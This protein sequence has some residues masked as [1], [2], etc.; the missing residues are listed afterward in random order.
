MASLAELWGW[1]MQWMGSHRRCDCCLC[2]EAQGCAPCSDSA[3]KAASTV[4]C[5]PFSSSHDIHCFLPQVCLLNSLLR[6]T[7][8]LSCS[9]AI[10]A[11]LFSHY[12]TLSPPPLVFVPRTW[13]TEHPDTCAQMALQ[14][15]TMAN[16]F[17]LSPALLQA[18]CISAS[19]KHCGGVKRHVVPALLSAEM[20]F[21]K[22]P[23]WWCS[24]AEGLVPDLQLPRADLK[25][26][27]NLA[28]SMN[29]WLSRETQTLLWENMAL[30]CPYLAT[31]QKSVVELECLISL[32][33]TSSPLTQ[34]L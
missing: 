31:P 9:P 19:W 26:S 14:P 24:W 16:G 23:F 22:K 10:S 11:L 1:G 7:C 20:S 5:F 29:H 15:G 3:C 21:R 18:D 28:T 25:P 6:R 17:A 32:T 12:L 2:G 33:L 30:V 34:S 4:V 27:P 8:P 13:S